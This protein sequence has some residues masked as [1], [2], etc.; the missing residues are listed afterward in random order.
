MICRHTRWNGRK[1]RSCWDGLHWRKDGWSLTRLVQQ[2]ER[3]VEW[4]QGLFYLILVENGFKGCVRNLWRTSSIIAKLW[5]LRDGLVMAQA[6]GIDYPIVELDALFVLQLVCNSDQTNLLLLPTVNDSRNL[7]QEL[8]GLEVKHAFKVSAIE[9]FI[10]LLE[11]RSTFTLARWGHTSWTNLQWE[12]LKFCILTNVESL[13]YLGPPFINRPSLVWISIC[14]G[15]SDLLIMTQ[16][17]LTPPIFIWRHMWK[18]YWRHG[19][20]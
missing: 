12:Y 17:D 18:K 2:M 7:L 16:D 5:G 9:R 14:T 8:Q 13:G 1:K 10:T 11:W 4:D 15:R 3:R 20:T 6:L 19:N